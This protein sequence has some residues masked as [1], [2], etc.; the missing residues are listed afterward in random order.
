[1]RHSPPA[2]DGEG[3]VSVRAIALLLGCVLAGCASHSFERTAEERRAAWDAGNVYPAAYRAELMAYLRTYLNDPTGVREA[4]I[5][6]PVLK[7]VGPGERYVAC[8]RFSPKRPGGGYAGAR[9]HLVVYVGGKLDRYVES[10]PAVE[11]CRGATYA[12]FPELERLTR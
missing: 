11:M 10:G 5:S 6:E 2:A 7:S 3:R 9:E 8:V 4:A 1:L 12:A